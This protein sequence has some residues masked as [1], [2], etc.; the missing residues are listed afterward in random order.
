MFLASSAPP[1]AGNATS[2]A[3]QPSD[4]GATSAASVPE[5]DILAPVAKTERIV[6]PLARD[7]D[8]SAGPRKNSVVQVTHREN[9]F[10]F[11][12]ENYGKSSRTIV[13]AICQLN[14]QINGPYD[15]LQAGE[16]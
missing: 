10:E 9:L 3:E 11:A 16:W 2:D 13:D 12:R 7:R 4:T 15:M 14:A 6:P 5:Q 8:R 1:M